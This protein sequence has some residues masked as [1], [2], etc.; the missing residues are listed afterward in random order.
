[1]SN[2]DKKSMK[3]AEKSKRPRRTRIEKAGPLYIDE[4]IKEPGWHYLIANDVPG[5]IKRRLNMGYEIVEDKNV[6]IGDKSVTNP[7]KITS[8]VTV[9]VGRSKEI[10]GILMRIR[11]EEYKEIMDEYDADALEQIED[12][13]D[14]VKGKIPNLYGQIKKT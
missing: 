1:M 3:L 7:S 10:K 12:V 6:D 13:L 4:S 9:D 8:T 14:D 2:L 11:D 5:S